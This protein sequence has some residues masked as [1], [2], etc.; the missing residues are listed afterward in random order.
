[1]RYCLCVHL[2]GSVTFYTWS[3]L[4]R[5]NLVLSSKPDLSFWKCL[6]LSAKLGGEGD[7]GKAS[8]WKACVHYLF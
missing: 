7:S 2:F 1:M 4:Q 6:S 8:S 3:S 5:L